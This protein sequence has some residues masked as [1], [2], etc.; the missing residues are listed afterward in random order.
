MSDRTCLD[1]RVP[2]AEWEQFRE[3]VEN[4]PGRLSG[5]L[6]R[7]A[8]A[9]MKEYTNTDA[10]A[11]VEEQIDRL[12]TAAG[13]TP[14]KPF[15][16]KKTQLADAETTR[17]MVRVDPAVKDDFRD[18]VG[19]EES[20]GVAFARAIRNYREGGRTARLERKLDRV[21]DDV[22][23]ALTKLEEKTAGSGGDSDA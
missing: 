5:S 17:V 1:W 21:L 22:D 16:E 11:T 2:K 18:T 9:A 8:E 15:K 3:Y 7:G 19:A 10:G 12:I 4:E 14:E 6:G 23:E 13:R 20:F